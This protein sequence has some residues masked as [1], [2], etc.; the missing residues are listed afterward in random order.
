[1]VS[2]PLLAICA[3][4]AGNSP[5]FTLGVT[6]SPTRVIF[7]YL[8]S[9]AEATQLNT[10]SLDITQLMEVGAHYGYSRTRRHPSTKQFLF[11]TKQSNDIINLEHTIPQ[12]DAALEF[13]KTVKQ[14]GR[15]ILFVGAKPEARDL[16]RAVGQATNMPYVENRWIGGTLTNWSVIK[17]RVDL[18][19]D[20]EKKQEANALVYKTKKEKLLIERKIEK[21]KKTFSGIQNLGGAPGVL[22]VIDSK[23]EDIAVTEAMKVGVP[24]VALC[25]TDCNLGLVTFPVLA[26]DTSRASIKL[27]LDTVM[28]TINS[29]E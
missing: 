10:M 2:S 22:V 20:L 11:G 7:S 13:L 4:L 27:F 17:G 5:N 1:M 3:K 15:Q 26:N 12:L 8:D 28:A 23:Q 24:V 25:N 18:L 19:T 16:V 14:S 21:L 6:E 9:C 29:N